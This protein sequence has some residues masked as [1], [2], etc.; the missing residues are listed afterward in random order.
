MGSSQGL[1]WGKHPV[2]FPSSGGRGVGAGE[3]IFPGR[4]GTPGPRCGSSSPARHLSGCSPRICK[5]GDIGPIRCL[6]KPSLREVGL[7]AQEHRACSV[8]GATSHPTG[9]LRSCRRVGWGHGTRGH[10]AGACRTGS[11]LCLIHPQAPSSL[12][13][14]DGCACP[15]G[16]VCL[17]TGTASTRLD[18]KVKFTGHPQCKGSVLEA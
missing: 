14:Q 1:T 7:L 6:S 9:E 8:T 15:A 11:R 4:L 17:V 5:K 10:L 18:P 3:G 12:L 2:C 16:W 13:P